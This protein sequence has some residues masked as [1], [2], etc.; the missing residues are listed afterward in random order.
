[1]LT[2]QQ[3]VCFSTEDW[4]TP[5]PTNKHQ[6]MVRLAKA[7]NEII[8]VETI[9]IRK[10][11]IRKADMKRIKQ[12]IQKS[13]S[14]PKAGTKN[15]T[16][17]S[18]LVI[19]GQGKGLKLKLNRI[20]FL[21]KLKKVLKEHH[22]KDP[23]LWVFNPFAV[24]FVDSIPHKFLVYHCVDDLSHIP[25][26]DSQAILDAE[27]VLLGKANIVFA[28]S[29]WLCEKCRHH[30]KNTHLQNNVG[31]FAHFSKVMDEST[32]VAPAVA[33][34]KHPVVMFVGNIAASKLDFEL[35]EQ[36]ALKR[37]DWSIVL[38]GPVW[39]DVSPLRLQRLQ[40]FNNLFMLPHVPYPQLPTYIKAADALIIPYQIN[41]YTKGVFPIKFFE[42]L[43][44][45]K[46]V[47]SI[48]LPSLH[49]YRDIVPLPGTH[50]AFSRAVDSVIKEEDINRDK[51][52][53]LAKQNTWEHRLEELSSLIQE[54]MAAS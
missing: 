50:Q 40:K 29:P 2:K 39:N 27:K 43:A 37:I 53:A 19:P 30:N 13:M 41:D 45:G 17:V 49:Q 33:K 3:I 18:P 22:I 24:H 34:F 5:L 46:P 20:L 23:I 16:V 10:P 38:V 35:I 25:G 44:T 28:T 4:D 26:A 6:L 48:D 8:Y 31:D 51:R 1:M 9:G 12:R 11:S 52:I 14:Q 7:N 15:L 21:P 32:P 36:I 47:V 42:F 54:S